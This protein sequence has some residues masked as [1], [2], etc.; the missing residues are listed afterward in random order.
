MRRLPISARRFGLAAD[1]TP[2]GDRAQARLQKGDLEGA[3]ADCDAVIRLA[4]GNPWLIDSAYC[5]RATIWA[6]AGSYAQAI[7]D[8]DYAIKLNPKQAGAYALA[9]WI[10]ATRPEA[11]FRDGKRA[12]EYATKAVDLSRSTNPDRPA[13]LAAAYAE[14]GDFQRAVEWQN[15]AISFAPKK[16]RP[17]FLS[18]LDLYKT[19]KPYREE[20]F[21]GSRRPTMYFETFIQ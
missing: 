18:A 3:I 15:K 6:T 13:I 14:T 12:V 1:F 16:D 19:G 21:N 17:D 9:A 2:Y 4:A 10:L 8:C 7:S 11:D 5:F 20:R